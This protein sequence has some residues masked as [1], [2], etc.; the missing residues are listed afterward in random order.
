M[1]FAPVRTLAK[2]L[3]SVPI[4]G[5][6]I[7]DRT[8]KFI[9]FSRHRLRVKVESYGS[10]AIEEGVVVGGEIKKPEIL[11]PQLAALKLQSGGIFRGRFVVASLP[12]EK[13]FLRIIQVPRVKVEK[14]QNAVRWELEGNIPIAPEEIYFDYEAVPSL[15]EKPDHFDVLTIAFPRT[16]V[17]T[18]VSVLRQAGFIPLALELESQSI[19]RALVDRKDLSTPRVF[20]DI[21]ASRTSFVLVGGGTI[22][23]TSTIQLSGVEFNKAIMRALN[24]SY[25]E[26]EE[27][28]KKDGLREDVN[29]GKVAVVLKPFLETLSDEIE[30]QI[31]FYRDHLSEHHGTSRD[32]ESI[33]L[34]GG[35]SSLI[36]LDAYLARALKKPVLMAN[37]FASLGTA[38]GDYMPPITQKDAMQFT[39]AIGLALR[40]MDI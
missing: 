3:L 26:A 25:E 24:V 28:K 2:R 32:I 39:T 35:D 17:D 34:T 8:V 1:L 21:G 40:D 12:E 20:V 19:A 27:I 10:V 37:S 31:E 23:L 13:S 7:S 14:L 5:L 22:I 29:G 6:D 11:V 33:V 16:I 9:R 38:F 36:G 15:D 4:V 18:Y 30:K